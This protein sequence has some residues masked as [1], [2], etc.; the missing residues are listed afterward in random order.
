MA[1]WHPFG[2]S[3]SSRRD[4]TQ[5][6][7]SAPGA[8]VGGG[9][10]AL[11]CDPCDKSFPNRRAM[12]QHLSSH[13]KCTECSFEASQAILGDHVQSVHSTGTRWTY[14]AA[15]IEKWRAER[16]KKYPSAQNVRKRERAEEDRESRGQV[17]STPMFRVGKGHY[18]DGKRPRKSGVGAGDESAPASAVGEA[19][20]VEAEET[21]AGPIGGG[22]V[23]YSSS[24]EDDDET[25]T[26]A[27]STAPPPVAPAVA[28][29][30]T[31]AAASAGPATPSDSKAGSDAQRFAAL[32][33][34][35]E[36][37][38]KR[39]KAGKY[40]ST[41]L[42]RLLAADIRRERNVVLQCIRHVVRHNF[43][44]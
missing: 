43:F 32:E 10:T 21:A 24:S 28:R 2:F 11:F 12:L 39:L 9:A 42:E 15:D 40:K 27:P 1:V 26:E 38:L 16:R 29:E 33:Q 36:D 35:M 4:P 19:A 6:L 18:R 44:D 13:V 7:A 5:G 41:L 30:G 3:T 34:S 25:P 37:P 8:S 31:A 14:D 22:L 17:A 20:A 23:A